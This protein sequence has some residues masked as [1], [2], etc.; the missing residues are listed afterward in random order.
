[1]AE[2]KLPRKFLASNIS[3]L[4]KRTYNL[5]DA[6]MESYAFMT[7]S[8]FH[9]H[10]GQSTEIAWNDV[11]EAG[12]INEYSGGLRKILIPSYPTEGYNQHSHTSEYDGGVIAGVNGSH[13]HTSNKT[14]GF[15]FAVFYPATGVPLSDWEE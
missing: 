8:Q 13:T 15:A 1:M 4:I 14:G 11:H 5:S 9:F 3:A 2:V 7:T 6:E 10:G 12:L